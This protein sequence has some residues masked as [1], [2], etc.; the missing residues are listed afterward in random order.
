MLFNLQ[1]LQFFNLITC[2]VFYIHYLTPLTSSLI[3]PFISW[4]FRVFIYSSKVSVLIQ[5]SSGIYWSFPFI[6]LHPINPQLAHSSNPIACLYECTLA[7]S[8]SIHDWVTFRQYTTYSISGSMFSKLYFFPIHVLL[9]LLQVPLFCCLSNPAPLSYTFRWLISLSLL[10][11]YLQFCYE[12]DL[13]KQHWN[14]INERKT[15]MSIK[16][17]FS[18]SIGNKKFE[19]CIS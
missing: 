12:I 13:Q 19:L 1:L 17:I 4:L 6:Y 15:K 11:R 18:M 3:R 7:Y 16:L 14:E 9:P 5:S 10:P 2:Y 8:H